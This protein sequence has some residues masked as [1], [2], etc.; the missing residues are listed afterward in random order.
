MWT[1]TT[2]TAVAVAAAVGLAACGSGAFDRPGGET[3][4]DPAT[5]TSGSTG[6]GGTT[7]GET[8]ETGTTGETTGGTGGPTGNGRRYG[9]FLPVGPDSPSFAEDNVYRQLATFRDC[10]AA[11]TTLEQEWRSMTSPRNVLLYDAAVALCRGDESRARAMYGR[12]GRYGWLVNTGGDGSGA[13]DCPT[14][15]AVRSVL[16]QREPQ[17]FPC[18]AGRPPGWPPPPGGPR[19]D[20]RTDANEATTTTTTSRTGG[21]GTTTTGRT[22]TTTTTTTTT[23]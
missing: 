8:G 5:A 21:A 17:S 2:T 16:D 15:Q 7:T 23:S 4:T 19:D 18:A 12:A 6:D 1:R 22:T 14:Y 20:P 9:W 10:G 11:K 3:T 13:V